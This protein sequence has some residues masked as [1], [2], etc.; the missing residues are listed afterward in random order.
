MHTQMHLST[1]HVHIKSSNHI[2]EMM[3]VAAKPIISTF[4][5]AAARASPLATLAP[6]FRLPMKAL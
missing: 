2:H 5:A 4:L 3:G 6:V 1:Q